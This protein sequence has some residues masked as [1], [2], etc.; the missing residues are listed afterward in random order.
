MT[1]FIR[2]QET[3]IDPEDIW[4][5]DAFGTLKN[6][7]DFLTNALVADGGNFVLNVNGAWGSGKSFFVNRWAEQLR[8][9][10]HPVVEFNAWE[11]DSVEDPLA[12]LVASLIDSQ[13]EIL[14]PTMGDKLKQGCGKYI[15]AGGGFIVR[16]GLKQLVG[17]KGIDSVNEMLSSGTENELIKLAGQHVE[18]QLEKQKAAKG[19]A[20]QLEAFVAAIEADVDLQLPIFIFIDELDRCRPTFAIELL[21]RVKHL[22]HVDGIKFVIST[23]STQLVH[24]IQGVYG[25]IF[26]SATYLQRFFDETFNLPDPN[27]EQ[28][29]TL[30]FKD[31]REVQKNLDE[32][33]IEHETAEKTF[34]NLADGFGMTLRQQTQAFHRINFIASNV[35]PTNHKA[36]HF[37]YVCALVMLRICNDPRYQSLIQEY[38]PEHQIRPVSKYELFR[39]VLADYKIANIYGGYLNRYMRIADGDSKNAMKM[40]NQ[41]SAEHEDD[42]IRMQRDEEVVVTG[43]ILGQ[44]FENFSEFQKYPMLIELTETLS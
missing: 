28:F 9:A 13:L 39:E 12:P 17:E 15:M 16:A 6:Y 23:D 36:F 18:E 33:W 20:E 26:D 29:A 40:A 11:N 25:A 42:R 44:C 10:G 30:L 4:G 32:L 22:F 37:I 21:E 31:L 1:Q 34:A 2:K 24:S 35:N 8:Q 7:A 5:N 19:I 3:E 41:F 14:P 38:R 43:W 27:S